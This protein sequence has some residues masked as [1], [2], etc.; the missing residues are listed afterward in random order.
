MKGKSH[1]QIKK[2]REF[3]VRTLKLAPNKYTSFGA[4]TF[5]VIGAIAYCV[6]VF[7]YWSEVVTASY[8]AGY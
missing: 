7:P 1:K 3:V 4:L 6:L 2:T 8:A 5:I